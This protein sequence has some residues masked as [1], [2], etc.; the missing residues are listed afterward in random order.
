MD[1]TADSTHPTSS[2]SRDELLERFAG[3]APRLSSLFPK[4][5]ESEYSKSLREYQPGAV[6]HAWNPKMKSERL[7][8]DDERVTAAYEAL[9]TVAKNAG[10]ELLDPANSEEQDLLICDM[11]TCARLAR[12]RQSAA[13]HDNQTFHQKVFS[14][15]DHQSR[16]APKYPASQRDL[17]ATVAKQ[18]RHQETSEE[19]SIT[20]SQQSGVNLLNDALSRATPTADLWDRASNELFQGVGRMVAFA[21]APEPDNDEDSSLQRDLAWIDGASSR[22]I[23]ACSAFIRAWDSA[24]TTDLTPQERYVHLEKVMAERGLAL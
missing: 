5:Y 2:E 11:L 12:M 13:L 20:E 3:L 7:K 19:L 15:V 18:R 10:F 6:H 22:E 17:K 4:V 16:Q 8:L 14:F 1:S 9:A 24:E 21:Q 23:E